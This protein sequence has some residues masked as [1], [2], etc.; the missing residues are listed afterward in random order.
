[1]PKALVSLTCTLALAACATAPPD[2]TATV[3]APAGAAD[4]PPASLLHSSPECVAKNLAAGEP[5][6]ASAIP[7][8]ARVRRQSG[9]VAV[10]Y[11]VV[12]G[13]A[14]NLTVVGSEPAG[15]YDAAALRHA[16]H[17]RDPGKATVSGCVMHI[18]VRF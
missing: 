16:A 7:E 4:A 8:A 2:R 10:R 11:D 1:M 17:Y 12:G 6:P 13:V 18:D 5:F 9:W 15:L 3:G 14:S